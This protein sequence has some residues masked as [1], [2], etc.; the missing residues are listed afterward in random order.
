MK[1]QGIPIFVIDRQAYWRDLTTEALRS[2]GYIV[3]PYADYDEEPPLAQEGQGFALALLGCRAVESEERQLVARLLAQKHAVIVLA[4]SFSIQ[5]MRALF[6][7]GV[8]DVVD[9]TYDADEIVQIV[10][11]TL[12]RLATRKRLRY[13]TERLIYY[14]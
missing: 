12:E 3:V 5:V 4:S 13:P 8:E 11:Q 7:K 6:I 2:S 1:N 9:R 14:E 10:E